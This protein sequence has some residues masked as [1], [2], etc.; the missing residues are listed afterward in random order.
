MET[1][2]KMEKRKKVDLLFIGNSHTF[3]NDMPATVRG[4][5]EAEGWECRVTM[6]AH[7][8]W[9]LA[10]HAGEPD[11]KFN[12]LRG[13]YDYVVLQEHAHPF[14]P[15]EKFRE[16]APVL[17]GM[18]REAGSRAV[19]FCT[20]ARKAEPEMQEHMNEVHREIARETGALAAPV[21]ER[22]QAYQREHPETEMYAG[23]GEHASPAGSAFAAGVIWE[24][25]REDLGRREPSGVQPPI[26]F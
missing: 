2:E 1:T 26:C 20:W 8:G 23:D 17:A 4:L 5:A 15:E 10:Q 16:A 18:I 3:Y 21:G 12:I 24:T 19:L 14:G 7:G 25:I 11:V 6:I 22:W 9:Y 13:R